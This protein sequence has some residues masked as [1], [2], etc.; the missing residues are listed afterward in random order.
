M[1]FNVLS[2]NKFKCSESNR[3]DEN[4][5]AQNI[6]ISILPKVQVSLFLVKDIFWWDISKSS[7]LCRRILLIRPTKTEITFTE[8]LLSM[9]GTTRCLR[10]WDFTCLVV[11]YYLQELFAGLRGWAWRRQSRG[12]R[13]EPWR[14]SPPH[15]TQLTTPSSVSALKPCVRL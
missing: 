12:S 1:C 10:R 11:C 8:M 3:T 4:N 2:Q 13:A 5:I 14:H 7:R 15:C 9:S 6:P